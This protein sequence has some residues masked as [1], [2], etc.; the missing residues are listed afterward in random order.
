MNKAYKYY[1]LEVTPVNDMENVACATYTAYDFM[2][3]DPDLVRW[4]V[5]NADG[6][7]KTVPDEIMRELSQNW[8]YRVKGI[9]G[10]TDK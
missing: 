10:G 5:E 7:W 3:Q 8:I 6:Q 4:A 9:C 1:A 2:K